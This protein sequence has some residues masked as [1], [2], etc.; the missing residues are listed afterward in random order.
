MSWTAE[1]PPL[2]QNEHRYAKVSEN[3]LGNK[4][5]GIGENV[6]RT[7]SLYRFLVQHQTMP[8][9]DLAAQI[10]EKGKPIFSVNDISE[11]QD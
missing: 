11:M 7:M 6:S 5:A 2:S 3:L 9:A 4:I 8:A 10:T 1:A